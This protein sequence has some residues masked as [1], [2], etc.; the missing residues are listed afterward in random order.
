[1]T[2]YNGK[3]YRC[4]EIDTNLRANSSFEDKKGNSKT[5]MDYYKEKYQIVI[6]D[7]NQPLIKVIEEDR[8]TK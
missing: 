3:F 7:E 1:M 8:R 2:S 5:Y 6:K 4:A